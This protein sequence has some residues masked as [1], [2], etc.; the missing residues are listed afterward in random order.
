MS[1]KEFVAGPYGTYYKG[2]YGTPN[3]WIEPEPCE[4]SK[5]GRI[6]EDYWGWLNL[7][8]NR[9]EIHERADKVPF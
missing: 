4:Q 7:P 1:Q 6:N 5:V 9:V 2:P 3:E 8:T